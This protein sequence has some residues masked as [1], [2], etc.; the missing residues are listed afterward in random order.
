[1]SA[2]GAATP[3]TSDKA[4]WHDGRWVRVPTTQRMHDGSLMPTWG[5]QVNGT[6]I[7]RAHPIGPSPAEQA[8]ARHHATL[9][10]A[11]K[12]MTGVLQEALA[13]FGAE[14]DADEDVPGADLVQWFIEWRERAKAA[15]GK[16][17]AP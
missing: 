15:L 3:A 13:A 8:L 11:S 5:V 6:W 4:A 1:M 7:G 14:F 12:G 16:A 2:A 17:G 9:F 10:A